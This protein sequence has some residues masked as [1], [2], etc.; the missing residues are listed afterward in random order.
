ML[1]DDLTSEEKKR[2]RNIHPLYKRLSGDVV[3]ALL[4]ENGFDDNVAGKL[5]DAVLD[6]MHGVVAAMSAVERNPQM[7]LTLKAK[8]PVCERCAVFHGTVL[9]S[10]N[11]QWIDFLP[12]FAVGCQM[13]CEVTSPH[14]KDESGCIDAAQLLAPEYSLLCPVLCADADGK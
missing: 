7:S 2:L 9:S 1:Y 11:P 13:T 12:P 5:M 14:A 3:W 6:E 10:V 8:G 4:Q